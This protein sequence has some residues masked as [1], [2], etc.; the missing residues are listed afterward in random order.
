[1]V[2]GLVGEPT[3]HKVRVPLSGATSAT[4][5]CPG[6]K[7]LGVKEGG[8]VE[9]EVSGPEAC[10]SPLEVSVWGPGGVRAVGVGVLSVTEAVDLGQ[11]EGVL[12][13]ETRRSV[14]LPG[15]LGEAK[16]VSSSPEVK[17][18]RVSGGAEGVEVGLLVPGTKEVS[19]PFRVTATG[20]DGRSVVG[21]GG[22][23]V[24]RAG[25]L[26]SVDG[27]VGRSVRQKVRLPVKGA[28]SAES[29]VPSVRVLSVSPEGELE[30]EV[31]GEKEMEG[32]LEL[33]A[34][35][36]DGQRVFGSGG[37]HVRELSDLGRVEGPVGQVA[38]RRVQVPVKG[39]AVSAEAT[40]PGVRVVGVTG[41]GEVELEVAGEKEVEEPL[42]VEVRCAD[43]SRWF[44]EGVLSVSSPESLGTLHG[45]VGQAWTRSV[46]VQVR[47]AREAMV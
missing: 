29:S 43:G 42:G 19:G 40:G 28:S 16:V 36:S 14:S 27:V 8:E 47:G 37:L 35:G 26:G 11:L 21:K 45:V 34:V 18:E 13:R 1:V 4:V 41:E 30:L 12:G 10:E 7:V 46:G 20:S 2:N 9:L 17:V 23:R 22:V 33:S 3:K 6:V 44:G 15:V 39:R 32:V 38:R 5:D 31:V 25:D 24:S